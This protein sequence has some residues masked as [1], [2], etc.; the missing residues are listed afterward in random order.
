MPPNQQILDAMRSAS[1]A[2]LFYFCRTV[3]GL[4]WMKPELHGQMCA[5]IQ[6][7]S[8]HHKL[9]LVPRDFGKTTI[10]KAR[11]LHGLIQSK[12]NNIYQPGIAGVDKRVI[13]AGET[14]TNASR[15]LRN[16]EH[17]IEH[18]QLFKSLWP[19]VKPGRKWSETEMELVRDTNYSEVTCEAVGTDTALASRH[20]DEIYED[21]IFTFEAS[22]S[23]TVAARVHA[24][25]A[26]LEPIL[27]TTENGQARQFFNATPWAPTDVARK[28][29]DDNER[30][31]SLGRKPKYAVYHR[32]AI[33]DDQSIWPARFPMSRLQQIEFDNEGTDFWQL[34]YMC[35]YTTG[36]NDLDSRWLHE[37]Q[38]VGDQLIFP[39]SELAGIS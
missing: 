25:H 14:A 26:A 22:Q 34:N 2:S 23:A 3:L 1:E 24:W 4:G 39:D 31:I 33:E 38:L 21:D 29:L 19:L 9:M 17:V 13:I 18:N 30:A 20:V 15:H 35:L 5:F 10:M 16:I 37:Y 7:P 27:D 32:S 11:I 8:E 36:S 28:I 12:S 6:D